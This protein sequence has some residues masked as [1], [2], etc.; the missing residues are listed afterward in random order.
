MAHVCL[1]Q[2]WPVIH[3]S[4]TSPRPGG[5]TEGPSTVESGSFLDSRKNENERESQGDTHHII[6]DT[7]TIVA[8]LKALKKR[9]S[10]SPSEPSF[11]RATPNTKAKRTKPKMFIPSISVPMGICRVRGDSGTKST[12]D[13]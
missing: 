12:T 11:F 1:Y 3:P 13:E 5:P 2:K 9:M 6:H 10:S 4:H 7:S 8:S